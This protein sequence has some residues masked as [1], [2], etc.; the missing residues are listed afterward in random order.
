MTDHTT[1]SS[2]AQEASSVPNLFRAL[3]IV[4]GTLDAKISAAFFACLAINENPSVRNVNT[5][6]RRLYF[7]GYRAAVVYDW[8]RRNRIA[9]TNAWMVGV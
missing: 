3:D 9:A 5:M 7:T 1:L 6:L 8:L 4:P 2:K